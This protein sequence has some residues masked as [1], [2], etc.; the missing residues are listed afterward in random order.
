MALKSMKD[1]NS[2]QPNVK[3]VIQQPK[4]EENPLQGFFSGGTKSRK[5]KRNPQETRKTFML[6][7]ALFAAA[8]ALSKIKPRT[9]IGS[10]SGRPIDAPNGSSNIARFRIDES[11]AE[12]VQAVIASFLRTSRESAWLQENTR[13]LLLANNV[14]IEDKEAVAVFLHNFVNNDLGV[15][16]DPEGFERIVSP[17]DLLFRWI[18][19]ANDP[20]RTDPIHEIVGGDCDDLA[21]LL[22]ALYFHAGIPSEVVIVDSDGDGIMDHAGVVAEVNGR[23]VFAETVVPGRPLGWEPD[24]QGQEVLF[25]S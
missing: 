14:D 4:S 1:A 3:V 21:L 7:G 9:A 19:A 12:R 23:R 25:I 20:G 13:A 6:L 2:G 11:N 15:I 8:F 16:P 5:A 17:E 24:I 18:E 22:A 10:L